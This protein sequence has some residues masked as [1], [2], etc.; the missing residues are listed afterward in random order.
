MQRSTGSRSTANLSEPVHRQL[1]AYAL[2]AGAAG[3]SLLALAEPSAAKIVYTKTHHVIGARSFYALDLNHDKITDFRIRVAGPTTGT[4]GTNWLLAQ[5]VRGNAVQ[6]YNSQTFGRVA[7]ALRKGARIGHSQGFISG[8]IRGETMEDVRQTD[9]FGIH[10][11]GQW[12]NVTNRY[13]GLRFKIHG[14]NHYGWARLSVRVQGRVITA[15]LTGYGYETIPN[16]SIIAGKTHGSLGDAVL[17]SDA[18][19]P[20]DP[21]PGA[22]LTNSLPDTPQPA[23]LGLLAMGSPALS[24]WRRRE[25]VGATK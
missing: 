6:S 18:T 13:L 7:A 3:V 2:A 1:N 22:L 23:S 9:G 12:A 20:A 8:G 25:S 4:A 21:R 15:T 5:E 24:V 14:K 17:G 10:Y 19:S 11:Y 16:K